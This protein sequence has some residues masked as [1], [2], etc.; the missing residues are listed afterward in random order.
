QGDTSADGGFPRGTAAS[1]SG[2]TI[3]GTWT[4]GTNAG[5][6]EQRP[7]INTSRG[8]YNTGTIASVIGSG[9]PVVCTVSGSG[10][11]WSSLGTGAKTDLFLEITGNSNGTTKH[12]IP[13]TSIT[14]DTHLVV[15]YALAEL[16]P[17]C[18][19]ALMVTSG[20]YNIYKGGSVAS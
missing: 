13:I 5:L 10:T 6:G 11:S 17:T 3:T 1:V 7:L 18:Y 12:V 15:E 16:G 2:N 20:V 4:A 19:G 9:S 14:D 8:V